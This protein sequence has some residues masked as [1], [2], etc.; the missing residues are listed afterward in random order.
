MCSILGGIKILHAQFPVLLKQDKKAHH[1]HYLLQGVRGHV[2]KNIEARLAVL[3]KSYKPPLNTAQYQAFTQQAPEQILNAMEPYGYYKPTI[4]AALLN[5][6]KPNVQAIFTIV[7]G[8]L[9][10]VTQLRIILDG[11]GKDE[12]FFKEIIKKFPLKVGD[13]LLIK[14]YIQGKQQLIDVATQEGYLKYQMALSRVAI[15]L[16]H[17]TS[18]I[19]IHFNTGERFYFGDVSFTKTPYNEEYLRRYIP[20]EKGAPFA[21][22][23]L[24]TF[25]DALSSS[26]QFKQ[27]TVLPEYN[28]VQQQSVPILV[29]LTPA[30]SQSYTFGAGY[31]TDTGARGTAGWNLLQVTP[32]GHK[33]QALIQASQLQNSVQA[34]YTIPGLQPTKEEYA[35]TASVYNLNYPGSKSNEAQLSGAYRK[36]EGDFQQAYSMNALLASY[37][38]EQDPRQDAFVLYPSA[39]W[40]WRQADSPIFAKNGYSLSFTTQGSAESLGSSVSFAQAEIQGKWA[41][42]IQPIHSRLYTRADLGI[43]SVD[44]ID[45][46]PPSLQFYTGGAQSVRGY[47]YQ[48]L[49]PGKALIAASAEWQQEVM[50]NGYLTFF[51]DAG[52]AFNNTP[53][54]L[55]RSIGGG[56]MWV[57]PIGPLHLS[58]A[59]ALDQNPNDTGPWHV[60]F[61]MGPDL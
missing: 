43:T 4:K 7:P 30:P 2:K 14:K 54:Q 12:S 47:S 37:T 6:G 23:E 5:P 29:E 18:D 40:K 1:V 59:K 27:V 10:R 36:H 48:S 42:T 41:K 55:M 35:M 28:D 31:G 53:V 26:D 33:F 13:P 20:F 44:S 39:N 50:K 32:S 34:Q 45:N 11:P 46:L 21:P 49:G 16:D 61:S 17:Y 22:S 38:I 24:T 19:T 60:V 25:Q 52:N 15:N 58:L 57:T 51:Y 3:E 56:I 9:M 8:P